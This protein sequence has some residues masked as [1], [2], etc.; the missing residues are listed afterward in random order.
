MAIKFK[1]IKINPGSYTFSKKAEARI[2][3]F[4]ED[5]TYNQKALQTKLAECLKFKKFNDREIKKFSY[6]QLAECLEF[7][8]FNDKEIKKCRQQL[9]M[10]DQGRPTTYWGDKWNNSRHKYK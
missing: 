9:K 2:E 5:G 10:I 1:N 7:K 3:M 4:N 8:K 6:S